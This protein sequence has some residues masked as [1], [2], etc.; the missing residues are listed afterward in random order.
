[1]FRATTQDDE[2]NQ[3]LKHF[4]EN[5]E[6][7]IMRAVSIFSGIEQYAI[8]PSGNVL[9]A[10]TSGDE[11]ELISFEMFRESFISQMKSVKILQYN[12]PSGK[13]L[14]LNDV[15]MDD[16]I[17]S[18]GVD[19]VNKECVTSVEY[20]E[21][22]ELFFP[23][24]GIIYPQ[25]IKR[26]YSSSDISK[27]Y[28][29]IYKNKIGKQEI[30]ARKH[31]SMLIGEPWNKVKM[32]ETVWIYLTLELRKWAI[33]HGYEYFR[34]LNTQESKGL[35]SYVAISYNSFDKKIS[36]YIF[37]E[38]RYM[39]VCVNKIKARAN[40]IFQSGAKNVS[41][42]ELVWCGSNPTEFWSNL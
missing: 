7:A 5:L 9:Y 37:D 39:D 15:W 27:L 35:F 26:E 1:M 6:T 18:G 38:N 31:R 4:G 34:Y 12:N 41:I 33:S 10:S 14:Q 21:L 22:K 24:S 28:K 32:Q 40:Y 16:P 30:S 29:V 20:D 23:F 17:A 2:N 42:D 36:E 19:I 13:S 11:V 3:I 8:L 25:D